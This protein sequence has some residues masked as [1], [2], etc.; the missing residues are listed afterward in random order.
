MDK[1]VAHHAVAHAA[2]LVHAAPA[3]AHPV[4]HHAVAH[5][6]PLVHAAPVA[7][8]AVH[9][10]PLV[11]AAPIVHAAP[12]VHAAPWLL[13]GDK[14]TITEAAVDSICAI[15]H[16]RGLTD[17]RE[18]SSCHLGPFFGFL[19]LLLS[20]AELGQVEGSKL[21]SL[22]NLLLVSLDLSLELV[23]QLRHAVLVLVVFISLEL[24]FLDVALSLLEG[25]VGLRGLA[26]NSSK[27][28]LKLTDA[29]LKLSHGIAATLGSKII[30]FSKPLLKLS[31]LRFKSTLCLLLGAG[32]FLLSS[33]FIS[34]AGSINHGSLGLLLRALGLREHVINLSMHGVNGTFKPALVSSSLGV[35]GCHVIDS[36]SSFTKLHVTSLLGTISRIKKGTRF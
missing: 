29:R 4:A 6:A 27:F 35:N 36:T 25:L 3:I 8:H 5:A 15:L 19:K 1:R 9:A 26:L 31:N 30:G 14:G 18:G 17:I 16:N 12:V 7:H 11:H 28:N 20:L 2:P 21:F 33:Q 23:G 22:L 34:K 24:E 32:V 13:D 10:A